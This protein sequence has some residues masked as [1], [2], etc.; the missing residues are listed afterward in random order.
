TATTTAQSMSAVLL[1][2]S[3]INGVDF[4]YNFDVVVNTNDSGQGS[5]EQFI[6]NANGLGN[7]G[8]LAQAG[9]RR[10]LAGS[11][12]ALP[13]GKET[14]LFMISDG[15]YHPGLRAGLMNQLASGVAVM[16]PSSL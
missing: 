10:S 9:S 1:N 7:E 6:V 5:L 14:S 2:A 3:D 8:S 11:N 16:A 15:S 13:S 4:G 12:E